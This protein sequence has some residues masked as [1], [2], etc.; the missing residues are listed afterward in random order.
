MEW[1]MF[2]KTMIKPPLS[3]IKGGNEFTPVFWAPFLSLETYRFT[4]HYR[5]S[6]W[7]RRCGRQGAGRMTFENCKPIEWGV[8][9]SSGLSGIYSGQVSIPLRQILNLRD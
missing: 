7:L 9:P 5:S 8:R 6:D 1:K 3:L 4:R 2:F